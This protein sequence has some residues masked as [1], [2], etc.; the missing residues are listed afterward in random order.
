M[1]SY[2]LILYIINL[3]SDV[4][5]CEQIYEV[6][7]SS[8]LTNSMNE[9]GSGIFGS[10]FAT[11]EIILFST[12]SSLFILFDRKGNIKLAISLISSIS[13]SF[14]YSE[15]L[16]GFLIAYGYYYSLMN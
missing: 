5:L 9:D 14:T 15:N 8:M 16:Y 10:K 2:K 12:A 1:K 13:S 3:C 6:I 11:I 4:K 7:F